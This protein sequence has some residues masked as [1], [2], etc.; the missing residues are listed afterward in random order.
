MRG[1]PKL[2][3]GGR[4]RRRS[5]LAS[6]HSFRGIFRFSRSEG[7]QIRLFEQERGRDS[8]L[9]SLSR[10]SPGKNLKG[11]PRAFLNG[12]PALREQR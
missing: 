10:E 6:R 4:S 3:S 2:G 8:S 1:E 7:N 9:V 12:N 11:Y 5:V